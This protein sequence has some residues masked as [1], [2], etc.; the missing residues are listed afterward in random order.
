MRRPSEL[1]HG[2]EKPVPDQG[3]ADDGPAM[4]R[5]ISS[6]ARRND[7]TVAEAEAFLRVVVN[8]CKPSG[9]AQRKRKK[10]TLSQRA[11]P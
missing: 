5:A 2:L 9:P 7:I 1:S 11:P 3:I 8:T 6:F 4:D 10:E